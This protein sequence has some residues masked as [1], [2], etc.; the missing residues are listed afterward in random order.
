MADAH[1]LYLCHT[2]IKHLYRFSLGEEVLYINTYMNTEFRMHCREQELFNTW[3]CHAGVPCAHTELMWSTWVTST[4]Q[5]TRAG[6]DLALC[7]S[8]WGLR[9]SSTFHTTFTC[10]QE[11][12]RRVPVLTSCFKVAILTLNASGMDNCRIK[13]G[14]GHVKEHSW[15]SEVY[16][17]TGLG[18]QL[19]VMVRGISV[20]LSFGSH[21]AL[22]LSVVK[23]TP[24]FFPSCSLMSAF[25]F[26]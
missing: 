17:C 7:L 1:S 3:G 9:S 18:F 16:Y 11:C 4:L 10:S 2:F 19:S 24:G 25:L 5:S 8:P 22:L 21:G 23:E 12:P 6:S 15:Q 13:A 14:S 20:P 26:P